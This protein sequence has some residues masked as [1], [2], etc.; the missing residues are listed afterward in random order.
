MNTCAVQNVATL[1]VADHICIWDKSRWPFRY[2]HH[3]IVFEEAADAESIVVA[4]VW[5]NKPGF[6]ES[7]Q[8]S[9]FQLTSLAE[10]L[11]GR[12]VD[13]MRRVQYNSSLLGDAFSK[14]GEVH[15]ARADT[16]P[17]VLARCKFLLGLG[18]GHFSIVSLNCEHVA[19]WCMTGV[20]WSK[21]LFQKAYSRVPYVTTKAE[22]LLSSLEASLDMLRGEARTRNRELAKLHGRRVYLQAGPVKF[23]KRI[24]GALYL[25]H[26]DPSERDMA[27]RQ[28]PTAFVLTVQVAAYNCVKVLLRVADSNEYIY[29]SANC[30]K[31]VARRSYHRESLFKFEL[32]W[33]GELQSR[34]NRRWYIGARTRD[35]LLR[36]FNT[37]DHAASFQIVDADKIDTDSVEIDQTLTATSEEDVGD[38]KLPVVEPTAPSL[39]IAGSKVESILSES[40]VTLVEVA[41]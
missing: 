15:R 17:V 23:V 27:F 19:L 35:G 41:E 4:H 6:R 14:L 24:G 21:Q 33:N 36:T 13:D 5:S 30:V 3:G 9:R 29:S 12:P 8:D 20:V 39:E 38:V 16:P 7:Q 1:R 2:T 34:R 11:N 31:L 40:S 32:G 22:H 28:Q 26:N 25:V 37:R 18:Q 10:F